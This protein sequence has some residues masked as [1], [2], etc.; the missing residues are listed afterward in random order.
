MYKCDKMLIFIIS[1]KGREEVGDQGVDHLVTIKRDMTEEEEEKGEGDITLLLT[2]AGVIED[3]DVLFQEKDVKIDI[4]TTTITI[5][6]TVAPV[7]LVTGDEAL[8]PHP[9]EDQ[10]DIVPLLPP[11]IM[12]GGITTLVTVATLICHLYE[13]D[14]LRKTRKNRRPP[15][16]IKVANIR[17]IIGV[18]GMVTR[19]TRGDIVLIV[20][21]NERVESR[22]KRS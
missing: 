14:Q 2:V 1:H 17:N 6:N 15:L 5:N 18:M 22:R 21:T 11:L 16:C 13:K 9:K 8:P 20:T 7:P 10:E 4:M 12:E 19:N 3:T